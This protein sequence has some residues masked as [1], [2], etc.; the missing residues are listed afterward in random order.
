MNEQNCFNKISCGK[1][2]K[3]KFLNGDSYHRQ[4]SIRTVESISKWRQLKENLDLPTY[5]L[6]IVLKKNWQKV[7]HVKLGR[8]MSHFLANIFF[9]TIPYTC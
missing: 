6:G 3:Q 1:M 9:R 4:N 2:V 8:D 7:R 5:F